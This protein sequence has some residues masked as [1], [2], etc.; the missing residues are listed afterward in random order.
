MVIFEK[1]VNIMA[2]EKVVNIMALEKLVNIMASLV[3]DK[4]LPADRSGQGDNR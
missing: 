1:V 3:V 2:L 4:Q